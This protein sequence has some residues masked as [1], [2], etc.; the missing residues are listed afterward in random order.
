MDKNK[1]SRRG[2][3]SLSDDE[4]RTHCVSVRLNKLELNWLDTHRQKNKKKYLRGEYLRMAG[5]GKL[6]KVVPGVN[7][8]TWLEL[9]AVGNNLNQIARLLN[10]GDRVIID[11]IV[12]VL[13]DLR[14]PLI[15]IKGD[16]NE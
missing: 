12:S 4:K 11:E 16:L 7:K 10:E 14:D 9:G 15:G 13:S 8:K 3:N 1:S 5:L 6:P 2:R